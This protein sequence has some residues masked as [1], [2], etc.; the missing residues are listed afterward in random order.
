MSIILQLKIAWVDK[1][2]GFRCREATGNIFVN[3]EPRNIKKFRDMSRYIMQQDLIQ[4][5]LSVEET[6]ILA[7]NLK[8]CK[9]ISLEEKIKSVSRS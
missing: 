9:S 8:M 6:M 3:G 7:A 2:R 5:L 1:K 4:P